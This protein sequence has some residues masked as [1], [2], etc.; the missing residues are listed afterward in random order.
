M[1][2]FCNSAAKAARSVRSATSK[3]ALTGT[4]ALRASVAISAWPSAA[5]RRR[6]A[7]R[8]AR[9]GVPPVMQTNAHDFRPVEAFLVEHVETV[10]HVAGEILG[11]AEAVVIVAVVVR[12]VGIGDDEIRF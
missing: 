4:S 7:A 8:G 11:R 5:R 1:V 9:S 10:D 6:R 3:C 2:C 12:L